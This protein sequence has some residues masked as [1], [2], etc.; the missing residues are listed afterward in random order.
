MIILDDNNF[1][2]GSVCLDVINQTWSPMFGNDLSLKLST[3]FVIWFKFFICQNVHFFQ[4]LSMYLRCFCHN[5]FCIPIHRT[6]WMEK[7]LHWW[8]VTELLMT[9]GLK[10][11][12]LSRSSSS[13]Y[14]DSLSVDIHLSHGYHRITMFSLMFSFALPNLS[15]N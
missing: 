12:I 11:F 13:E 4:I 1:R 3:K 2:S 7:L 15:Y 9:K 5:S 6:P 10:V 14:I 8:C